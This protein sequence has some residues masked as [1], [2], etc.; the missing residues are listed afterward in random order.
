MKI[1][2]INLFSCD[3]VEHR[4]EFILKSIKELNNTK[5]INNFK[6]IIHAGTKVFKLREI[7]VRSIVFTLVMGLLAL[8]GGMI[9]GGLL[10]HSKYLLEIEFFRGVK[11]S[12]MLPLVVFVILYK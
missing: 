5:N 6:L 11:I 12:E 7:I 9:V 1:L 4:K 3:Y 8:L 10:S 2:Q